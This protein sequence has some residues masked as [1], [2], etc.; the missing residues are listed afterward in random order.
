VNQSS[1]HSEFSTF[2]K[3]MENK[4][5]PPLINLAYRNTSTYCLMEGQ[6]TSFR[7]TV[8]IILIWKCG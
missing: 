3:S 6:F 8:H 2:P 4:R 1:V 7:L 5:M